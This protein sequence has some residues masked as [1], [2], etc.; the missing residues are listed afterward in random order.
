[1][2]LG[3]AETGLFAAG[4]STL[5]TPV[6]RSIA[7]RLGALDL[8]NERSSHSVPTPR[9]GGYAIVIAI[10]VGALVAGAFW[11]SR[12]L[13][14]GTGSLVLIA[15]AAVDEVRT[16]S[17]VGRFIA[18]L[19]VG[20]LVAFALRPAQPIAS[21]VLLLVLLGVATLWTV[22]MTNAYNFM[23]GINGLASSSAVVAGVTMAIL[24]SQAGDLPAAG[25]AVAI[26]GAAAGFFAWN[27]TGT[28]FMG[29]VGSSTLGFLFAC[30]VLRARGDG[31]LIPA[32]LPLA[33]ILFDATLTLIIRAV[34]GER[35]FSTPH[36][37]HCYQLLVQRGW[38]HPSVTAIWFG[39]AIV[40]A[41]VALDW[42][43]L[44]TLG[45]VVAGVAL[46][47]AH[48][49]VFA[50]SR[51]REVPPLVSSGGLG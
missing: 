47:A 4:I 11:D 20:A 8:P 2:I 33:P 42:Q 6:A 17:R 46:L 39:L 21:E 31:L 23:D 26:A 43:R 51:R 27:M 16:L 12:L 49:L 24:F 22:W 32:V 18:Q 15:L 1:M 14:V 38:S 19:L 25:L 44:G 7:R 48:F 10:A 45:R 13:A 29:D 36:R 28:I 5:L 41:A 3:L 34:R 35:F 50:L 9:T 37:S 40:C 30:L